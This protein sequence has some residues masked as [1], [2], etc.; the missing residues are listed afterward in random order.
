VSGAL[1]LAWRK[2]PPPSLPG[3]GSAIVLSLSC[4]ASL[5]LSPPLLQSGGLFHGPLHNI[6]L[7]KDVWMKGG[8]HTHFPRTNLKYANGLL[9]G[10][11]SFLLRVRQHSTEQIY[12]NAK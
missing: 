7:E 9:F 11:V 3:L 1:T 8:E 4:P 6:F 5:P 10:V 12:E 2:A